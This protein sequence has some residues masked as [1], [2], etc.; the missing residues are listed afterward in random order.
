MVKIDKK[1]GIIAIILI[2]AGILAGYG[3]LQTQP[4]QDENRIIVAD[5]A[6]THHLNLYVAK[7]KG[8]FAKHGVNVEIVKSENLAA[9]RDSVVAGA[10]DVFWACPTLG[11]STIGGGAP[12]RKIAQVKIPCTSVL[13]VPADS[14][15]Q[16]YKDLD[17]KT[18]A[19]ISPTCEAVIAITRAAEKAGAK[20]NLTKM[21][22]GTAVAALKA[23]EVDGAILEEPHASIA[24]LAG[25]RVMF[26]E[27]AEAIPCRT[28]S[29]RTGF[30][31]ENPDA[32]RRMIKAV[33]EANAI[34]NA[35]PEAADIVEIA[36]K[37]TGAPKDA[38]IHGNHR[39][40]FTIHL[41]EEGLC[42]LGDE[43]VAMGTIKE[44]PKDILFAPEFRGITWN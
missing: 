27:A 17:G 24:E 40:K 19:G 26:R 10:A 34:I 32:L 29:A 35:D 6:T 21:D 14:P 20:F 13:L 15:I 9:A 22:G 36:H 31:K 3:L 12:I 28:I 38:I 16:N 8:L 25:F 37:Y 23:G 2:S 18:I 44:C 43:L 33:D 7:E 42:K 11:I 39:L 4:L 1:I 5:A 41:D 30:L